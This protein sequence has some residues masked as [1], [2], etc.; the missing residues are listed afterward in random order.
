MF[1]PLTYSIWCPG[2]QDLQIFQMILINS[3][4]DIP[5]SPLVAN[6]SGWN[7]MLFLVPSSG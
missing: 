4:L 1:S 7:L 5:I 2:H 6:L 3:F